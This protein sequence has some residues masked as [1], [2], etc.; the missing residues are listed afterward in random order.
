[1]VA[2]SFGSYA[3]SIF[4]DGGAASA[5]VFAVVVVVAMTGLNIAG[6]TSV[7]RVQSLIVVVVV[8]IL[9]SFAA[10]T[11]ANLNPTLLAPSGYPGSA[12][13][14]RVWR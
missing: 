2:V 10:V 12:T 5:K 7:A 13:S 4:A 6:S 1:M 9:A 11:I 14:S 3:S 8:G